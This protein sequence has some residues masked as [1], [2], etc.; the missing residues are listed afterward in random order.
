[1]RYDDAAFSGRIDGQ[2]SDRASGSRLGAAADFRVEERGPQASTVVLDITYALRGALAQVARGPIAK[3]F[4]A[5]IAET[6]GRNLEARL[7]GEAVS[8]ALPRLGAG[9]LMTRSL[10]RWL[11]GL[12]SRHHEG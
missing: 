6:V 8:A 7:R 4:A 9:R 2:G 12:L 10:W 5:E 1:V 3:V 11:K